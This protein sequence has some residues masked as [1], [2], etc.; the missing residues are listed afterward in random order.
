MGLQQH[1]SKPLK[2]GD[3]GFAQALQSESLQT[4]SNEQ[5]GQVL[6]LAML[7]VG[8]RAQNLPS[9]EEKM[10][11]LAFIRSKYGG[12]KLAELRLAFEL[13]VAGELNL[14]ESGATCYENFSCEYIGRIMSAYR[15]W[16]K[17]QHKALPIEPP[18]GLLEYRMPRIDWAD[19]WEHVK[20]MAAAGNI[21]KC[22]IVTPLYDWLAENGL[23]NLSGPEKKQFYIS[24]RSAMI[25]QLNEE[26]N[27]GNLSFE[28]RQD[29][30]DLRR[31]DW[32]KVERLKTK[33]QNKS[34]ILA[35]KWLALK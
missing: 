8:I 33:L 19:E 30:E 12:H 18:K 24:A 21:E 11:L 22:I 10:V 27:T 28:Q 32:F 17:E 9:D 15:Q 5:I 31:E 1:E 4:A 34:K 2:T 14:G 6:R 13:A 16:A 20:E 29:L 35:V 26:K 23:I 25:S 3:N 7:M